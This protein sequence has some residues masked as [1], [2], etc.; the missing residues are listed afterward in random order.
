MPVGTARR[1]SRLPGAAIPLGQRPHAVREE[2]I[3]H[4]AARKDS[5]PREGGSVPSSHAEH[6]LSADDRGIGADAACHDRAFLH[7]RVAHDAAGF[8]P[9]CG[10]LLVALGLLCPSLIHI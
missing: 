2:I 3:T 5:L 4:F 10:F 8:P 7:G 9:Y 6:L 1:N